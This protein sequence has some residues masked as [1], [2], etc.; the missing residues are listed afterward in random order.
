MAVVRLDSVDEILNV[1]HA[2]RT[3]GVS[4]DNAAEYIKAGAAALGVGGKL[5][6]KAAVKR[7]DWSALTA[8]GHCLM[9]AVRL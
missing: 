1:A 8:E 4:P 3:G 5:V 2:L 7:G 9:A 6:D